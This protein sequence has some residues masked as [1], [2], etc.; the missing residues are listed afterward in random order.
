MPRVTAIGKHAAILP[1]K[2][3]GVGLCD[4]ETVDEAKAALRKIRDD[5]EETLI[6][7][8]EDIAAEC[9]YEI[10]H[11]RQGTSV[12]IMTLPAS[13]GEIGVQR[14]RVRQLVARSLGVDLM[15]KK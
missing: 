12:V 1:F 5:G 4:V 7:I 6:L 3:V 14:E 15:G 8:P 2:A 9:E 10:A 11:I 13:G